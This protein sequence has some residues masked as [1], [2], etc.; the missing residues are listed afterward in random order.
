LEKCQEKR[1]FSSVFNGAP[2]KDKVVKQLKNNALGVEI[3]AHEILIKDFK[4]RYAFRF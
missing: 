2:M 3:V 4:I 1:R